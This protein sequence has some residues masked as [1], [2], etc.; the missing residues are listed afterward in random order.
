MQT[1]GPIFICVIVGDFWV[2]CCSWRSNESLAEKVG[3]LLHKLELSWIYLTCSHML[4]AF[5]LSSKKGQSRCNYWTLAIS[6]P[7]L[8]SSLQ[9]WASVDSWGLSEVDHRSTTKMLVSHLKEFTKEI[10]IRE[11]LWAEK[12]WI[13][14]LL[15]QYHWFQNIRQILGRKLVKWKFTFSW[16]S[17]RLWD[18]KWQCINQIISY[19]V[20]I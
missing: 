5:F 20:H 16:E 10:S 14:L 17:I 1:S 18:S 7:W 12:W 19:L 3:V 6:Y 2:H 9:S 13:P 15:K 8:S 4:C 11:F